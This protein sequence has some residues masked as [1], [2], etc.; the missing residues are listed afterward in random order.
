MT[1]DQAMEAL[2]TKLGVWLPLGQQQFL[3]S[4]LR[5]EEA[6]NFIDKIE[7]LVTTIDAMPVT[8]EQESLGDQAIVHLHYFRGGADWWIT[9]KDK[10]GG[11]LQAFG[12]VQLHGGDPEP[13]YIDITEVIAL[14]V[15]MDFYWTAKTVKDA[16]K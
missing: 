14:G 15:E 4:A 7:E 11:V 9:E 10:Q 5:G 16:I 1:K 12:W 8:Y 6:Q 3:A 13:G 2:S